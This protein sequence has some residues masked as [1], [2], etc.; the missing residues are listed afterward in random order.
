MRLSVRED[1]QPGTVI[2]SVG[3]PER[4][5]GTVY[6]IAEGDGSLHFG[7][8]RSSGELRVIRELDHEATTRYL[9]K[10]RVEDGGQGRNRSTSV[11]V[12]ISVEDVNDHTPWFADDIIVFGLEENWPE[13]RPVYTFNAKDGDG[14]WRNSDL[15]YAIAKG[16]GVEPPFRIDPR[17]GTLTA[18]GPVDRER[19]ANIAF[20]VTA[21]DQALQPSDRRSGTLTVHVFLLDVNDNA[22]T[23]V[24]SGL[25]H[26]LEDTETGSLVHRLVTKDN[27][28]GENGQV[29][30]TILSG[31]KEDLFT[32][33]E[34]TGRSS[35]GCC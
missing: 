35:V 32:L 12:S 22:P 33:E 4:F 27:D 10:V 13:G 15:R 7:I 26:I 17:T 8:D 9:L 14:S 31:N 16:N 34:S 5:P 30:Y 6:S 21:T 24:S 19:T 1:C 29:T 18:A 2:G 23:F 3:S 28:L 25:V 11:F 20:T